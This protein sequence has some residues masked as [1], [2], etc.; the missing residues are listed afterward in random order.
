MLCAKRN[1]HFASYCY[2]YDG[3]RHRH[4]LIVLQ[5]LM[6]SCVVYGPSVVP[7][8]GYKK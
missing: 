8:V 2:V 7:D 5:T 3:G 4:M 1:S 6:I